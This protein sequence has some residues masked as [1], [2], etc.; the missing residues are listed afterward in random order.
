MQY[1]TP[2]FAR[3]TLE[4]GA[5]LAFSQYVRL[6]MLPAA[7]EV[8][9]NWL[10]VRNVPAP[11]IAELNAALVT[12]GPG[13]ISLLEDTAASDTVE[14]WK[15]AIAPL[16]LVHLLLGSTFSTPINAW[17]LVAARAMS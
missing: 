1:V 15:T 6:R 5:V 14:V 9:P 16:A 11:T 12:M 17:N 13:V 10:T 4:D 7:V 2:S 8:K 3:A